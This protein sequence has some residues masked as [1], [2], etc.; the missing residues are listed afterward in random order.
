MICKDWRKEYRR[1]TTDNGGGVRGIGTD[2][3]GQGLVV[4]FTF[5]SQ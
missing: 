5:F 4:F 2:T 3:Q 1:E